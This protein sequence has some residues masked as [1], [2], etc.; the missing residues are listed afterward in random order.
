LVER[1]NQLAAARYS[2]PPFQP[3]TPKIAEFLPV[4]SRTQS[5]VKVKAIGQ[6]EFSK[7]VPGAAMAGLGGLRLWKT[8]L[9]KARGTPAAIICSAL[10]RRRTPVPCL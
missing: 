4:F 10:A 3:T 2:F 6:P 7:S 8:P 9:E 5:A 1:P